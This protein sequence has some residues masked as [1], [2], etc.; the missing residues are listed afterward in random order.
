M[1]NF[2]A[3]ALVFLSVAGSGCSSPQTAKTLSSG[4]DTVRETGQDR[5]LKTTS[6][7]RNGG[8]FTAVIEAVTILDELRY[9]LTVRLTTMAALEGMDAPS[10][11]G[12]HLDLSP[13]YVLD[14]NGTVDLSNERNKRLMTLRSAKPGDEV[15]GKI[16]L[17]PEKGW[18]ILDVEE[19]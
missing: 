11:Q 9:R 13:E 16:S 10:G 17:V 6:L 14:A 4:Q 8:V 12:Q 15:T 7:K 5:E 3:L 18:V 1:E 19:L 2:L